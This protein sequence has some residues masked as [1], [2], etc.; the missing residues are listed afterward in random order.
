MTTKVMTTL[1]AKAALKKILEAQ[2]EAACPVCKAN[3]GIPFLVRKL[4]R[5][6][7]TR[8]K[9]PTAVHAETHF[10]N[11]GDDWLGWWNTAAIEG[12]TLLPDEWETSTP[13]DKL[14][15]GRDTKRPWRFVLE[16]HKAITDAGIRCEYRERRYR[17][18][19]HARYCVF[20]DSNFWSL[21]V[22]AGKGVKGAREYHGLLMG[23]I[24]ETKKQVEA[25]PPSQEAPPQGTSL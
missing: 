22:E 8:A 25:P 6:K 24:A 7:S 4:K 23:I 18:L 20:L 12:L 11:A 2:G 21:I 16:N 13:A 9:S 19:G 5:G 14:A 10:D 15:E 3:G 17:E 1:Q